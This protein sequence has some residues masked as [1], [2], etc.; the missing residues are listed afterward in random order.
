MRTVKIFSLL[1]VLLS[2]FNSCQKEF[3][4]EGGTITLLPGTWEFRDSNTL[5]RGDMDTAFVETS[6]S[7]KTLRLQGT[8]FNG[9]ED[10]E[11]V[12]N[13][14]GAAFTTGTY[15]ASNG[16][17][18]FEYSKN[19]QVLYEANQLLGE[20][21]VTISS[22]SATSVTGTFTGFANDSLGRQ[23]TLTAGKFTSRYNN[24]TTTGNAVGTLG[25]TAGS[26]TPTSNTGIFMQGVALDSSNKV[27]V[28]VNI[29]QPGVYNI[30]TN[31]VN[32]VSFS[33][34]GT[35]TTTGTQTVTL[36]GSGTPTSSG[37]Q[38]YTVTF[39]TSTCTF[40]ITYQAAA[41]PSVGTLGGGP[42]A[43]TPATVAGTYAQGVAMNSGNTVTIQATVTTAGSY[44]ISTNTLNGISFS[45]SGVFTTTGPQTVVLQAT[46]TPTAAGTQTFTVT[47][48][49]S[50]CTFPITCT[51]PPVALDYF[52]TTTN[53]NW[54]YYGTT[55]LAFYDSA[56]T[57]ATNLTTTFGGNTYTRF[58]TL[59]LNNAVATVD[60][61][62]YRKTTNNYFELMNVGDFFGFSNPQYADVNFLKD[63][64]AAG[65]TWSSPTYS[66]T[67]NGAPA[68]GSFKFTILAQGVSATVGSL[69]FPDV[70]KVKND[71][72][73][74]ASPTNP[75]LTITTWYAKGV[76]IIYIDFGGF[77]ADNIQRYQVF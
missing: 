65:G 64:L 46:G 36:A 56:K 73:F 41:P 74:T 43:C 35:F 40:T 49:T 10:F 9:L 77:D 58:H 21:I 44:T 17:A 52:P 69:T 55:G 38:T 19:G 8:S 76:G 29:T 42:G 32:G 71:I 33:K 5:Y 26:C 34:S 3:S 18:S 61:S 67:Y 39:G 16:A 70:I 2:I 25:A 66:G 31:T 30:S 4:L 50:T 48:G 63:N 75:A 68:Q 54:V 24:G 23:K 7:T 13:T 14:T 11:L 1:V 60:T 57:T 15:M 20:F 47:Y 51:A 22:I 59:E 45:K 37:A 53:S 28:T 72:T 6:G 12:L 27:T 62:Y